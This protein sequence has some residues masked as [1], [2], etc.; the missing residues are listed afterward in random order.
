MAANALP[1]ATYYV[2]TTGADTNGGLS[3]SDAKLTIQAAL[4]LCTGR[5]LNTVFVGSGGFAE[6]LQTP[7]NTTTSPAPFGQLIAARPTSMGFGTY[8]TAATSSGTILTV[9]ARGWRISGFEL[10]I[11]TTG[12]G[13]DLDSLSTDC[14]AHYT[15]IDNC[16]IFGQGNAT[17]G[18]DFNNQSNWVLIEDCDFVT[19]TNIGAT[20]QAI[21]SSNSTTGNANFPIIRRCRFVG[22]NKNIHLDGL[23]GFNS[24]LI[25]DCIFMNDSTTTASE[26]INLT[27]GGYN[28]VRRNI[29]P[30][31]WS[32][33]GGWVDATGDIWAENYAVNGALLTTQPT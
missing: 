4:D 14:K 11:P 19:I 13:I 3:W 26:Y 29:C 32:H 8:L 24:G 30:G 31:T 1:G 15:Q 18:I 28:V 5:G 25:E 23:R 33:T 7:L 10:E 27:G 20:A 16:L 17:L 6:S 21:G 9:R 2:A 22:N 12:K